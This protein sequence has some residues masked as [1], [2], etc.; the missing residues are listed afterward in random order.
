V[1][2]RNAAVELGLHPGG[3]SFPRDVG[4]VGM[5]RLARRAQ[6]NSM[7]KTRPPQPGKPLAHALLSDFATGLLEPWEAEEQGPAA[8]A[9]RFAHYQGKPVEFC[10]DILRVT[11]T[12]EVEDML[13]AAQEKPSTLARSANATGKTIAAAFFIIYWFLV[14]EDA[15]VYTAAAPPED[16]LRLLLWGEIG[17]L[18]EAHPELF[19]GFKVSLASMRI[20]RNKRSFVVGLAI[21]QSA[22]PQQI[23]ARFSG[24]HAPHLLF[25]FD[26]G[27]GIPKPVYDATEGCMSG[28]FARQLILFN[29]RSKSGAV[30]QMETSG[31]G[32]VVTLKAFNHPNVLTG[33]DLIPGA[34]TRE[35]TVRRI[36][37]WTEPVAP[38]EIADGPDCFEVPRFLV[39]YVAHDM[40]GTAFPPLPP[41]KRRIKAADFFTKVLGEYPLQAEDQLISEVWIDAAVTRYKLWRARYGAAPSGIRPVMGL[42]V[43]ELGSDS[44]VVTFK[45]GSY[46]APQ[47]IWGGVDTEITGNR[48]AD[49]FFNHN[50][51]W[52]NVD[53]TGIGAGA[54]AR[55]RR[56]RGCNAHRIMVGSTKDLKRGEEELATVE[57]IEVSGFNSIRSQ[58]LW[59]VREWLR[60]DSGA[61][62]PD[63]PELKDEL[64][65]PTYG[66]TVK[67]L[68]FV[69]STDTMKETLK[70]SPDR[71]MSL[72]LIFAR[73]PE[74]LAGE[75]GVTSYASGEIGKNGRH[76]KP[77][78]LTML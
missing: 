64:L 67:E 55:M 58:M 52:A 5:G 32:Y 77:N 50:A 45:Y 48:A 2:V 35:M 33:N 54:W 23:K 53:A 8:A 68:I 41:G 38:G 21:P 22:D 11:L 72:G 74:N 29:P 14:Y 15:Q 4:M 63:D 70:R 31:G 36:N 13:R 27:D 6:V 49:L 62:L 73:Q 12:D 47:I 66:K 51:L 1:E 78:G 57:Q 20:E 43:A 40:N 19:Y 10:H 60:L 7:L 37:I 65:A 75:L 25:V 34:V 76:G 30:Y 46:V 16:N 39:G 56:G 59:G 3:S 42:D 18:V 61:M 44:N 28:G 71:L 26:E 24:K 17:A 69:C 9:G